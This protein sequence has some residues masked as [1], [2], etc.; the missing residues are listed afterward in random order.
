MPS[1][2]KCVQDFE[3]CGYCELCF[4]YFKPNPPTFDT[5]AENQ[6]CPLAAIKRKYV[7]EPYFEYTID[8]SL[9]IG[10]ALCV[11]GCTT[12]GNGSF[13]LQVRHDRCLN[14]NECSIAVACP[15]SAF[16]RRPASD[17]YVIKHEGQGNL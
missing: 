1:A 13:Y 8:E 9:C 10:C 3:L 15:A 17:P 14:C 16:I 5:G 6:L 2:V 11:K 12:F 4:G 7:E